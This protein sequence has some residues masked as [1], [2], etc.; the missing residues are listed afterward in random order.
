[1]SRKKE[2]FS[3]AVKEVVS[4]YTPG[5]TEEA[6][7]VEEV[8]QEQPEK[9]QDSVQEQKPNDK[10]RKKLDYNAKETKSRRLQ[11]LIKPSIYEQLEEL[12][13]TLKPQYSERE[14]KHITIND[15]INRILED[16]LENL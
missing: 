9:E 12:R 5:L 7:T 13:D 15:L 8:N 2:S 11:I 6:E 16:Y 10:T 1:M 3:G 14:A 4:F